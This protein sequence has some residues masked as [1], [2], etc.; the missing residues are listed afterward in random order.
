M[1]VEFTL[2][3][4][5]TSARVQL[6]TSLLDVLRDNLALAGSKSACDQGECASC[7]VVFDCEVV[8]SGLVITLVAMRAPKQLSEEVPEMDLLVL[9]GTT[10]TLLQLRKTALNG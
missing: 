1:I 6:P 3:D 4:V 7:S 9:L 2:N 10:G 5:A 8:G